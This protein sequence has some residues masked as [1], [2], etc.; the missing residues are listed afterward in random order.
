[1][2][3]DNG[4]LNLKYLI[5]LCLKTLKNVNLL[6]LLWIFRLK[7]NNEKKILYN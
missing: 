1:M 4:S 6:Y 3:K 5:L 7:K 2:D